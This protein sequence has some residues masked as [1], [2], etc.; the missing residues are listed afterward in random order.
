LSEFHKDKHARDGVKTTCKD[1]NKAASAATKERYRNRP[2]VTVG[3][4][5]CSDCEVEK[6]VD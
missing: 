5:K 4:K 3:M 1:C 2:K 6:P